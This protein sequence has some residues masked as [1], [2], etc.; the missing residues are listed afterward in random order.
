[1][2]SCPAGVTSSAWTIGG[3]C[4]PDPP[5]VAGLEPTRVGMTVALRGPQRKPRN[6]RAPMTTNQ[7][8]QM[9]EARQLIAKLGGI[10]LGAASTATTPARAAY[11]HAPVAYPH[12]PVAYPHAAAAYPHAPVAYPHAPVAYPHAPVARPEV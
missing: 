5:R 7:S 1:M 3:A 11:P 10:A 2:L 12:A 9:E 6:G 8:N 4:K